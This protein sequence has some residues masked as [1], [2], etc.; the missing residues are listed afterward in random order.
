MVKKQK[1]VFVLPENGLRVP[2]TMGGAIETLLT[3]LLERNEKERKFQFVFIFPTS[4][5]EKTYYECAVCYGCT[6][7]S[8]GGVAGEFCKK[9]WIKIGL[10]FPKL[11]PRVSKYYRK[12]CRIAKREKADYVIAEG[13]LPDQF[14]NFGYVWKRESLGTHLH[15]QY[16]KTQRCDEIFGKTIAISEFI[17]DRWNEKT[18]EQWKNT[19]VLHNCIDIDKFNVPISEERKNEIRREMGF[20]PEDFIV[21]FCGRLVAQ[22]GVKELIDAVLNIDDPAIKLLLIGSDDFARGDKGKYAQEIKET[23][24]QNSDKIS[25]LGYIENG[26]IYQ[27]YQSADMQVIP[28]TWEEPAGLVVLEGMMSKIPL[29]ITRSGGMVEYVDEEYTEII[30]N[31]ENIVENIRNKIL[32]LKKDSGKRERMA[33]G[34]YKWVRQFTSQKYY[35]DFCA[36]MDDWSYNK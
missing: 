7:K 8:I 31:D 12:A 1:I 30:P 27:Y 4:Q 20:C 16:V 15:N 33:E 22:K 10:Y 18:P 35:E 26:L 21:I 17:A 23:V 28:S 14:I 24:R 2:A 11:F 19:Y 13:I 3:M 25:H 29:V 32:E 5:A 36:I 6:V 34:A 9:V